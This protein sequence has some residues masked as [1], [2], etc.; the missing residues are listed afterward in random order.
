MNPDR[1]RV[2]FNVFPWRT[3]AT[4][5]TTEAAT[6]PDPLTWAQS[7]RPP[8]ANDAEREPQRTLTTQD[9]L[10]DPD[11][12][13]DSIEGF[14]D[15]ASLTVQLLIAQHPNTANAT[16]LALAHTGNVLVLRSILLREHCDAVVIETIFESPLCDN[17]QL[18]TAALSSTNTPASV[19]S[20][21]CVQNPTW[22]PLML[23]RNP[24]A[25]TALLDDMYRFVCGNEF[26][27]VAGDRMFQW[28]VYEE[29][30]AVELARHPNTSDL[31]RVELAGH[32]K[33]T[34]REAVYWHFAR[35]CAPQ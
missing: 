11:C 35:L 13:S 27:D 2:T 34:V 32:E 29:A 10:S 9:L 16:L 15:T 24:N 26:A 21:L 14:R 7:T 17:S 4:E 12:D 30:V 19:L 20:H 3:P 22:V 31:V 23:C 1:P 28:P 33:Q 18:V 8:E 5:P 6:E 25:P